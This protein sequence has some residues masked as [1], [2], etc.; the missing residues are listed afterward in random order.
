MF[1]VSL[2][3][4]MHN[5]NACHVS[6]LFLNC[7]FLFIYFIIIPLML[8]FL[9]CCTVSNFHLYYYPCSS[10]RVCILQLLN[11]KTVCFP[12]HVTTAF[13]IHTWVPHP[14]PETCL[15]RRHI[16]TGFLG[17]AQ[18]NRT[19]QTSVPLSGALIKGTPT[20]SS[21]E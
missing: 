6:F 10:L 13:T 8:Y 1:F 20:P 16:A 21:R 12:D 11:K 14:A 7:T 4:F 15:Y 19:C 2:L 9:Y 3:P 5:L 17:S 18:N